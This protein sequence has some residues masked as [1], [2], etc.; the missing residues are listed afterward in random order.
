MAMNYHAHRVSN[1]QQ[2]YA[3]LVNLWC[4]LMSAITQDAA[5]ASLLVSRSEDTCKLRT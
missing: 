5:K 2:I 4:S 1:Q 3:S